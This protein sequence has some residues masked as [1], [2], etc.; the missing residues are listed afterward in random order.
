MQEVKQLIALNFEK[1]KKKTKAVMQK[2]KFGLRT[3]AHGLSTDF[4]H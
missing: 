2:N 1:F 3:R 4:K